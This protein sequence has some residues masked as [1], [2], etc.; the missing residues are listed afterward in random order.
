MVRLFTK[1][2]EQQLF[3]LYGLLK[4]EKHCE[5]ETQTR[6]NQALARYAMT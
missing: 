3:L 4:L 6:I 5:K 1:E 2:Q